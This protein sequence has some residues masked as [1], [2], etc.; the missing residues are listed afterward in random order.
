MSL[1]RPFLLLA[2]AAALG[3]A[4][5]PVPA[6]AKEESKIQINLDP[7]SGVA[8]PGRSNTSKLKTLFMP[9]TA[10]IQVQ[11]QGLAPA[12]EYLLLSDGIEITRF[13]TGSNGQANVKIDLLQL[14]T[15]GDLGVAVVDPRG[16]FVTLNDGVADVQ[17]GWLYGPVE[18]DPS[19]VLVNESTNLA[20]DALAAPTGSATANYM[21][22]PNR[23]GKLR[24]S[25]IGAPVGDYEVWIDG[26]LVGTMTTNP[27]G[28]AS[29]EFRSDAPH[30]NSGG[31]GKPN[32][33]NKP[34]KQGNVK[35]PMDFD[36]R[37][38]LIELLQGG[39]VV[40]SGEMAAQIG[41][42]NVCLPFEAGAPLALAP[43]QA[44]GAGTVS[45]GQEDD[46]S[47]T[48]TIA[49]TGLAPGVYDLVVADVVV[50][51]LTVAADGTGTVR[52]DT[53][54]DDLDE[55]PL[56]FSLPSGATIAIELGGVEVLVGTVP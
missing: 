52:F 10:G 56:D 53:S 39:V 22:T 28:N 13:T 2:A 50:G 17:G 8:G 19:R 44:A 15:T 49:V 45:F 47:R 40:F 4:M 18:L 48:F 21:M 23:K 32:K 36:P 1:S 11:V 38:A 30:G 9:G 34:K 31:N 20:P 26:V 43:G 42:L 33:P 6:L 51:A 16:T 12:T 14:A 3:V 7:L 46:C 55:L 25:T 29:V 24:I 5:A 41:G 35:L 27:A 54:P 37:M